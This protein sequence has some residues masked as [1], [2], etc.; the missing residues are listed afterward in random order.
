MATYQYV[1]AGM[2]IRGLIPPQQLEP[3]SLSRTFPILTPHKTYNVTADSTSIVQMKTDADIRRPPWYLT[4][5]I[6]VKRT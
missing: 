5:L 1:C 3:H 6:R 4:N 2:L